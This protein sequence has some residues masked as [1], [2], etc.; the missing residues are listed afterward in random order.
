MCF[1]KEQMA[2]DRVVMPE[3]TERLI[4]ILLIVITLPVLLIRVGQYA[5]IR[6]VHVTKNNRYSIEQYFLK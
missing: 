1:Q 5:W 6:S 4:N 2:T 3:S